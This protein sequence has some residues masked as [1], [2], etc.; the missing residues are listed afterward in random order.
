MGS[1]LTHI[2]KFLDIEKIR[3]QQDEAFLAESVDLADL[4]RR[5]KIL[6]NTHTRRHNYGYGNDYS[7][8]FH[9]TLQSF[10]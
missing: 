3:K 6:E 5:L 2:F 9:L 7:N 10:R 4:E 1:I 8:N